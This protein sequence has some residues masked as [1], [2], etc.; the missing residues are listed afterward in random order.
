MKIQMKLLTC[1]L[2]A[3]WFLGLSAVGTGIALA[4]RPYDLSD[5]TKSFIDW[6]YKVVSFEV[7]GDSYN[8]TH[9]VRFDVAY[10]QVLKDFLSAYQTKKPFGNFQLMGVTENKDGFRCILAY[11]NEHHYVDVSP[12]GSG[13]VAVVQAMPSSYITGIYD[14]AAYG[15]RMPDG[16]TLPIGLNNKDGL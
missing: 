15:F 7:S 1:V 11:N 14:V 5:I 12:S 9:I 13:T 4:D 8:M 3:V 16:G 2:S 10:N 6:P